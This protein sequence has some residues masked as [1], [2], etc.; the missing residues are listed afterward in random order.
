MSIW[1]PAL[2]FIF[3]RVETALIAEVSECASGHGGIMKHV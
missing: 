1:A 2:I 3:G